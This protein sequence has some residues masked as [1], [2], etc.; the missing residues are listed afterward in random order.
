MEV[1]IVDMKVNQFKDMNG[2]YVRLGDSVR[3]CG[4][5]TQIGLCTVIQRNQ[6]IREKPFVVKDLRGNIYYFNSEWTLLM[7]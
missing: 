6:C 4:V 2:D 3:P 5:N 1:V 7:P